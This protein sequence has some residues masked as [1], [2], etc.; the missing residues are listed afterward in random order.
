LLSDELFN[1]YAVF[2]FTVSFLVIERVLIDMLSVV[3]MIVVV[4]SVVGPLKAYNL[5]PLKSI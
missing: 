3:I 4:L 2:L 1:S 5:I